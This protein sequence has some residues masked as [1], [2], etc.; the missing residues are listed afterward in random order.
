MSLMFYYIYLCVYVYM[1]KSEDNLPESVSPS[2][3]VLGV[4][5]TYVLTLGVTLRSSHLVTSTSTHWATPPAL[6]GIF[7]V[8]GYVEKLYIKKIFLSRQYITLGLESR[9]WDSREISQ[10]P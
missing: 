5:H 6:T 7:F 2:V 4:N 1:W 9:L 3:W 10:D 8:V